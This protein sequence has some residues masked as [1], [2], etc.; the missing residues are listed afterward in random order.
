[1][2]KVFGEVFCEVF[3]LGAYSRGLG[4][5]GQLCG[6]TEIALIEIEAVKKAA[7]FTKKATAC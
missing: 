2:Y 7:T 5:T 3:W 4:S 1:M 6:R